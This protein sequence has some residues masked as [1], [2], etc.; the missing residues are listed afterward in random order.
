MPAGPEDGVLANDPAAYKQACDEILAG[1][2]RDVRIFAPDLDAALLNREQVQEALVRLTHHNRNARVRILV[3]DGD[4]V[5]SQGHRLVHLARRLSSF[6]SIRV[7]AVDSRD[8]SHC[9][10]LAD[11]KALLWRPDYGQLRHGMVQHNDPA[12]SG[13]LSR[14]F[15]K[16]WEQSTSAVAL[17]QLHL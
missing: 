12:R 8:V 4:K 13:A 9:W 6:I 3:A 1:A 14:Q 5:A 11:G 17:R 2:R 7:L 16:H 15:D 10:L